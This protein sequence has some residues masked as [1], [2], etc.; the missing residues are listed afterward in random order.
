ML[1][2]PLSLFSVLLSRFK[3][4]SRLWLD[5]LFFA[6]AKIAI[7]WASPFRLLVAKRTGINSPYVNTLSSLSLY[8]QHQEFVPPRFCILWKLPFAEWSWHCARCSLNSLWDKNQEDWRAWLLPL[9]SEQ[10]WEVVESG[11]PVTFWLI[12]SVPRLPF[13]PTSCVVAKRCCSRVLRGGMSVLNHT[14]RSCEVVSPA[15][16]VVSVLLCWWFNSWWAAK[17]HNI[18]L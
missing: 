16:S 10:C 8:L 9:V 11:C 4:F 15:S 5:A 14:I 6:L 17:Y 1:P 2:I 7:N 3:E 13:S 12:S 18:P